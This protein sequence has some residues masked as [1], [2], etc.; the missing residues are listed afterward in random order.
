MNRTKLQEPQAPGRRPRGRRRNGQTM[1]EFVFLLPLLFGLLFVQLDV[2]FAIYAQSTLLQAV[3]EGVRYGVTNSSP[4]GC[5]GTVTACV[6]QTVV[7]AANGLL[8]GAFGNTSSKVQVTYYAYNPGVGLEVVS[9]SWTTVAPN[10]GGNVMVVSVN[11]YSL[12][13]LVPVILMGQGWGSVSN[14]PMTFTVSA[15]DRIEPIN[16]PPAY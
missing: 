2:A 9:S 4:S 1:I 5:G 8:S 11:S 10:A 14:S 7:T 13:M 16:N 6:T 15:A 12:P 3:R